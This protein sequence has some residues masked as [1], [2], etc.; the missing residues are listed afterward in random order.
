VIKFS[1]AQSLRYAALL[2]RYR[3]SERVNGQS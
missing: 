2:G 3:P 1:Q